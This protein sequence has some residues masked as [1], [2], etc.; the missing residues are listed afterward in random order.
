[1]NNEEENTNS[2]LSGV[3][4]VDVPAYTGGKVSNL[5][6]CNDGVTQL[7]VTETD[8]CALVGTA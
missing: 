5:F 7:Y 6:D 4:D 8:R 3:G 1:M 2:V